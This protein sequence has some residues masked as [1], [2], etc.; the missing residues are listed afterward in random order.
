MI[1]FDTS[2]FHKPLDDEWLN[3]LYICLNSISNWS[4]FQGKKIYRPIYYHED[5]TYVSKEQIMK[6]S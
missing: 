1:I 2:K 3:G 4:I 6:M 5:Q